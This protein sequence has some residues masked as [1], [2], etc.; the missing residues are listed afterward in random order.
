[1]KV[2]N[3]VGKIMATFNGIDLEKM[4]GF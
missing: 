1:M 4:K 2:L 3:D